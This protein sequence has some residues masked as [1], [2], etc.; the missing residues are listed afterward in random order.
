MI[1]NNNFLRYNPAK[2]FWNVGGSTTQVYSSAAV[3]YVPITDATYTAFLASG[4]FPTAID[5]EANL[6]LVLSMA[7]PA[8]WPQTLA[9]QA[10]AAIGAGLT[11]TSPTI[12]LASVTFDCGAVTQD[13]IQS[14]AVALLLTGAFADGSAT[15]PW[16]DLAGVNHTM[17]V[18]QFK[19]FAGAQG[20][21]VAAL[22]KVLNG[23]LVTLPSASMTIA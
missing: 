19:T 1:F 13:H 17:T 23:T 12:P 4:G 14:E 10:E 22:Y 7:Y 8:G 2:W 5:T 11:L 15:V 20:A 21:Y 6:A 18:A 16:P 9:Q 3:A